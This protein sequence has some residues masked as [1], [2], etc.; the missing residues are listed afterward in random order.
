MQKSQRTLQHGTQNVKTH[1]RT[2]KKTET[3]INTDP[4]KTGS[5]TRVLVKGKQFLL[6]IRHSPCYTYIQSSSVQVFAMQK[7]KH[8]SAKQ[9]PGQTFVD[10]FL[11]KDNHFRTSK[12]TSLTSLVT[13]HAVFLL[14][15]NR[16]YA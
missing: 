7:V 14:D 13:S 16:K 6:L 10:E 15:K 12:G 5:E 2:T 3:I 8:V 4:P 11:Q 1:N 9:R